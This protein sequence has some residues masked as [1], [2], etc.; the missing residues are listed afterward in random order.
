MDTIILSFQIWAPFIWFERSGYFVCWW[1]ARSRKMFGY[2]LSSCSFPR[3][4]LN[5]KFQG[6]AA[7]WLDAS[8]GHSEVW[9]C[10]FFTKLRWRAGLKSETSSLL[11]QAVSLHQSSKFGFIWVLEKI[12]LSSDFFRCRYIFNSKVVELSDVLL[13]TK[14]LLKTLPVFKNSKALWGK[15]S[16]GNFK[17]QKFIE[18]PQLLCS[19]Y[20]TPEQWVRFQM[21][22][23]AFVVK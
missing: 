9:I 1:K 14:I 22:M 7:L 12:I 19:V 8:Q 5:Y 11:Q 21:K 17:K 20:L 23:V 18:I 15:K 16:R 3:K 10:S 13:R 4:G 6:W 2:L